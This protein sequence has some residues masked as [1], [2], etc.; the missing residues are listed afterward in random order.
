MYLFNSFLFIVDRGGIKLT[1][2]L[3]SPCLNKNY[4]PSMSKKVK[5]AGGTPRRL[6]VSHSPF[7]GAN[8][9]GEGTGYFRSSGKHIWKLI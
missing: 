1:S 7:I 9:C 5:M 6:C 8:F 2:L 4:L 3:G